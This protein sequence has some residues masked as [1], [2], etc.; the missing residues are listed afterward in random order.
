[1]DS[2]QNRK[3]LERQARSLILSKDI[4]I[5]DRDRINLLMRNQDISFEERYTDIISILKKSPDK[6][7]ADIEDEDDVQETKKPQTIKR[8][9]TATAVKREPVSLQPSARKYPDINGPTETKLYIND[10]FLKYKRY[11]LFRK[12]Y[13]ARR[14]NRFGIGF[15]KRLIPTKKFLLLI[16]DI[17]SFQENILSRLPQILERILKDETI[18][19]PLEFNYL[20]QLRRWMIIAPFASIPYERIKWME[21]W[22]FERELKSYT[23]YFHSFL[24]VDSE[25]REK[26]LSMVEKFLREE[27]DLLKEEILESDD[28][29]DAIRKENENYRKEKYIFEYL[30]A[31]RSFMAIHGEADSLLAAFL[32]K[33]YEVFTLEELLNMTI[34]AIVFQRPFSGS[35]LREYFEI[36]PLSI[37]NEIWDISSARL[38][39]YGKD[40]ESKRRRE[41]ERL[42]KELSWFDTIYQSVRI[43][44]NGQ[45]ILVKSV[46]DQWKYVDRIN[47]DA[48]D[49][50]KNNFIV[51]LEGM[52]L[53]F[54]NLFVPVLNGDPLFFDL[55][56]NTSEGAIFSRDFFIDE[57]RD[58]DQL[59]A[60]IYTFRNINPTLKINEDELKKIVSGKITSMNHVEGI[61][62]KAGS[63]FYSFGNK[64]HEVYHNHKAAVTKSGKTELKTIPLKP[65]DKD[66]DVVIPFSVCMLKE[67]DH[68]T[69]LIR[70]IEGKKILSSSMKGG[71][72]VFIMA[73]CYQAALVCGYPQMQIDLGRRDIIR[74]Q[75]REL[76][77]EE[78][79]SE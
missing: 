72:I 33:K 75:I 74:R 35:E 50:C 71:I 10:I 47:R 54:K 29:S 65:E 67:F 51:F 57:L 3:R 60:D 1:M 21:Q 8:T 59:A 37:S 38:K 48:A 11:K 6:E 77:G 64:L 42:I 18:E 34:E 69:P 49:S 23:V 52:I 7:I 24:R 16:S 39:F 45:S 62:F 22:D 79:A 53:Y 56:G 19:M 25:P 68:Q 66:S 76:K 63:C 40:P 55:Y 13:L 30:G 20:R 78:N 61:V 41:A 46:E 28:R 15:S 32:K 17:K 70:R 31:L 2:E 73:Y 9:P 27:P 4:S 12:R 26:V 43:D 44:E 58:L 5:S 36:R 14:D